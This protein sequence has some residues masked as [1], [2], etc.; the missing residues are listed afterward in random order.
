MGGERVV[1][2]W[3]VGFSVIIAL[4]YSGYEVG[5]QKNSTNNLFTYLLT[6]VLII[7]L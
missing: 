2:F 5:T 1:K 7:L 4:N 6:I 3:Q